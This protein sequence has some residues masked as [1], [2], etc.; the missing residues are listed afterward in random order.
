MVTSVWGDSF[1]PAGGELRTTCPAG[2]LDG[3][4]GPRAQASDEPSRALI[5]A[6]LLRP[7]SSGTTPAPFDVEGV[8]LGSGAAEDAPVTNRESGFGHD[9]SPPYFLLTAVWMPFQTQCRMVAACV[10]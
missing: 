4:A 1:V 2:R 5:A 10:L 8:A 7:F 6:C 9:L 3:T